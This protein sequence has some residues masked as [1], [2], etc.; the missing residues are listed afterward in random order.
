MTDLLNSLLSTLDEQRRRVLQTLDGLPDEAMTGS[1]VPSGWAPLGVIRHL[2]IDVE[3]FWFQGVVA[4]EAL[5]L[6][7]DDDVWHPTPWPA[8]QLVVNEYQAAAARSDDIIRATPLDALPPTQALS[9]YPWAPGG[10]CWRRCC[11]SS[12]RRPRMPATSTLHA[13]SSMAVKTSSSRSSRG[14]TPEGW[15]GAK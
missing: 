8:R 1:M 2:T 5:D 14:L 9:A 12:R 10:A 3:H 7:T 4:G 11:T 15:I 6:P 13:S